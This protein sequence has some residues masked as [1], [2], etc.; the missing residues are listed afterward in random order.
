MLKSFILCAVYYSF[1]TPAREMNAAKWGFR[2]HFCKDESSVLAPIPLVPVIGRRGAGGGG[3]K[4]KGKEK[5]REEKR[6]EDTIAI[7]LSA[8]VSSS[9]MLFICSFICLFM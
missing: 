1:M 6:R 7:N 5:R 3:E 2:P 9:L 8:M 4:R